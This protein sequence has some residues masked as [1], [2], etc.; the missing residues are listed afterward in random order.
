M[1]KNRDN[2]AIKSSASYSITEVV[3]EQQCQGGV[4]V[5]SGTD[6]RFGSHPQTHVIP[7]ELIM[8][9]QW[10]LRCV[11]H[12]TPVKHSAL[13]CVG[14]VCQGS[15]WVYLSH[16]YQSC[17]RS[18]LAM[19]QLLWDISPNFSL[20]CCCLSNIW[21][22]TECLL[23]WPSGNLRQVWLTSFMLVSSGSV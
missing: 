12:Q 10:C 17:D 9:P 22:V 19:K 23:Q 2:K 15:P 14:S 7:T 6:S 20:P 1:L 8:K 5:R 21:K 18:H 13:C 3:K 11:W 16:N 4:R